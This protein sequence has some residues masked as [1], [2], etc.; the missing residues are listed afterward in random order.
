MNSPIEDFVNIDYEFR[1]SGRSAGREMPAPQINNTSPRACASISLSGIAAKP[2]PKEMTRSSTDMS[3]LN[4][5][6]P[7][8]SL[9]RA[10]NLIGTYPTSCINRT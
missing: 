4:S 5:C 10:A 9:A 1:K 7:H 6:P 2:G 3:V 8:A